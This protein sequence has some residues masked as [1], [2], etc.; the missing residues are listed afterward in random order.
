MTDPPANDPLPYRSAVADEAT[1]R[2]RPAL[3]AAGAV[4]IAKLVQDGT[5]WISGGSAWL[6][7]AGASWHNALTVLLMFVDGVVG[8]L[9]VAAAVAI[10][11]HRPRARR[12][13]LAALG[14]W[15]AAALAGCIISVA[16]RMGAGS[17]LSFPIVTWR[18]MV[19]APNAVAGEIQTLV[20]PLL[21]WWL[22]L[23]RPP[24]LP[25]AIPPLAEDAASR[26]PSPVQRT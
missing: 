19:S 8:V 16:R 3:L 18:T 7:I 24:A 11:Q 23:R 25:D 26:S 9:L 15:T 20:L 2:H 14:T 10:W 22:I 6:R 5:F 4:G 21:L 13:M 1:T 12:L 17:S